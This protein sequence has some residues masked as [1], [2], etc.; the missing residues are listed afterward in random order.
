M[1]FAE[2]KRVSVKGQLNLDVHGHEIWTVA[3]TRPGHSGGRSLAT[4][5]HLWSE[6]LARSS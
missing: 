1:D 2:V 5:R 4:R 3:A 6:K